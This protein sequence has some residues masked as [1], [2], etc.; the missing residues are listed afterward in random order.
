[1]CPFAAYFKLIMSHGTR[2]YWGERSKW[3]MQAGFELA[4][5]IKNKRPTARPSR[6]FKILCV[7]RI[8]PVKNPPPCFNPNV[9]YI[10]PSDTWRAI[11][12]YNGHI[13]T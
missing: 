11:D 7:K 2:G 1:M 13:E 3:H 6:R 8:N 9:F 4:T 12:F 10:E 5:V